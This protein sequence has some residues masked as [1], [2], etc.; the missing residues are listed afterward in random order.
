MSNR[1]IF[2]LG[3]LGLA[4]L[5]VAVK[6]N[7]LNVNYLISRPSDE[8]DYSDYI[9]F[10]TLL[11]FEH[12]L[13]NEELSSLMSDFSRLLNRSGYSHLRQTF[14]D[15]LP[16]HRLR[17]G[18][19]LLSDS[20]K[21]IESILSTNGLKDSMNSFL[22]EFYAVAIRYKSLLD[23]VFPQGFI[24]DGTPS[25]DWSSYDQPPRIKVST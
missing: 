13:S 7:F 15:N 4:S 16:E 6:V 18:L 8:L 19:V 14:T 2:L 12:R 3:T 20:E 9:F 11:P 1:R 24:A 23:T 17:L 21:S 10:R 25:L 22:D 5:A